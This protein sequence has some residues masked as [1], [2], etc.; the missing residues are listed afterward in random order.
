MI[1]K[2][3]H[4]FGKITEKR[5][6]TNSLQ[7]CSNPSDEKEINIY[8]IIRRFDVSGFHAIYDYNGSFEFRKFK[9]EY[10]NT[11]I[12]QTIIASSIHSPFIPPFILYDEWSMC[13]VCRVSFPKSWKILSH[14]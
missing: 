6:M 1:A 12:E 13:R 8:L 7:L 14:S 3:I 4:L 2:I 9:R 10:I 5:G 11:C